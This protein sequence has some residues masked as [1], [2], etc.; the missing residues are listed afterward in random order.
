MLDVK[1]L[2]VTA[3]TDKSYCIRLPFKLKW[4]KPLA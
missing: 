2:S 4:D 1:E 3:K